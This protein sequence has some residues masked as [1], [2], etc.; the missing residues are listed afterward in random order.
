MVDVKTAFG[1]F[2][3]ENGDY[4]KFKQVPSTHVMN[5]NIPTDPKPGTF[6]DKMRQNMEKQIRA[7]ESD[8]QVIQEALHLST[9]VLDG[10][11]TVQDLISVARK[12]IEE[13]SKH[14]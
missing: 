14:L 2:G 8:E 5:W 1:E 11:D 6:G 4:R 7:V 12:R 10:V 13:S 9:V 3:D